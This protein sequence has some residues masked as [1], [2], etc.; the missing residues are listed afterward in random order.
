MMDS[1][2]KPNSPDST[3]PVILTPLCTT[4]LISLYASPDKW[5]FNNSCPSL[6]NRHG[7]DK[8]SR[9]RNFPIHTLHFCLSQFCFCRMSDRYHS[10]GRRLLG[11]PL[12]YFSG[13][14]HSI[15][16]VLTKVLKHFWILRSEKAQ[17]GQLHPLQR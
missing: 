8:I 12:F 17:P 11:A 16:P 3:E 15:C 4:S 9:P 10:W 6:W 1:G 2:L 7:V 13:F 14:S 5:N